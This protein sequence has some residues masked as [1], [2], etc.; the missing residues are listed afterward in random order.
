MIASCCLSIIDT[1]SGN[2]FKL[3]QDSFI[4]A[5]IILS[6]SGQQENDTQGM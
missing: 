5:E 2:I 1:H 4:E 6:F 3:S